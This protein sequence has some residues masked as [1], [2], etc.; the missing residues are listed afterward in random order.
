MHSLG[1]P[2]VWQVDFHQMMALDKKFTR[3]ILI[4]PVSTTFYSNPSNSQVIDEVIGM[5]HLATRNICTKFYSNPSN[6]IQFTGE[7]R[8]KVRGSPKWLTA[9]SSWGSWMSAHNLLTINT[10]VIEM[11]QSASQPAV[12]SSVS[13]SNRHIPRTCSKHS[14]ALKRMNLSLLYTPQSSP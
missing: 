12:L 13:T 11:F 2:L 9:R 14:H 3:D 6:F 10:E 8:H 4:H 1:M 5:D 7:T